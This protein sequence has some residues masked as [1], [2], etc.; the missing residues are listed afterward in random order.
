MCPGSGARRARAPAS[1][2]YPAGGLHWRFTGTLLAVSVS[3][4]GRGG[5]WAVLR[6]RGLALAGAL[7]CEVYPVGKLQ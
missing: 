5:L 7:P 2:I 4:C 3:G 6:V 1:G